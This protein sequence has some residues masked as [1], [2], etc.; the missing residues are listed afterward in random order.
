[1]SHELQL[2]GE[3]MSTF[4]KALNLNA[5]GP[6]NWKVLGIK[7]YA[8]L[9]LRSAG[10]FP[11]CC[12]SALLTVFPHKISQGKPDSQCPWFPFSGFD[13]ER[14]SSSLELSLNDT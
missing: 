11:D 5:G 7:F 6:T 12:T 13:E 1:M 14:G 8:L 9:I 10:A 2:L 4:N 3:A